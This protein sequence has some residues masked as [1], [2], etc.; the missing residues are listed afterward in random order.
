MV[1]ALFCQHKQKRQENDMKETF[2]LLFFVA[3]VAALSVAG[4]FD[5]QEAERA[6]DEYTEM[7]CLF[8]ETSGEFGWPDFKNLKITCGE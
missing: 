2:T 3:L 4:A 5:R 8:K 1:E 7:V 6:A